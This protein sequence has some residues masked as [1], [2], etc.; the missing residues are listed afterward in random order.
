MLVAAPRS[1]RY[2]ALV[3]LAPVASSGSTASAGGPDSRLLVKFRPGI[4]GVS[5]RAEIAAL[6]AREAPWVS[7][8][9]D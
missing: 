9:L 5:A 4:S 8:R 7:W 2:L 6:G 1:T 3:L